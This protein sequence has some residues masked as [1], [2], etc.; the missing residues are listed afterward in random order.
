MSRTHTAAICILIADGEHARLIRPDANGVLVSTRHFD[1]AAMHLDT[2]DL[3]SD[4]QGRSYESGASAH[5]AIEPRHDPHALAKARF[6]R[7]LGKAL[8]TEVAQ[9]GVDRL[10]LV[11]PSHSLAEIEATLDTAAT[12]LVVGRLAKDLVKTPD[13]ALWEHVAEWVPRAHPPR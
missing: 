6:A 8:N 7:S 3:V 13:D 4:R 5:H 12:A 1:S 10:I 2:H 11:A 9:G